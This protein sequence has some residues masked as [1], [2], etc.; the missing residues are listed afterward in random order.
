MRR[1]I[2][3]SAL[4]L[5]MLLPQEARPQTAQSILAT[6]RTRQIERWNGVK[7]YTLIQTIQG[8]ETPSYYERMEVNGQPGFRLV[9]ITE[10]RKRAPGTPQDPDAMAGGMADALD[11]LDQGFAQEIGPVHNLFMHS[12]LN[13]MSTVLRMSQEYHE[14][15]GRADVATADSGMA[16]FMSRARLAGRETM[17]GRDAFRLIADNVSDIVLTD[18]GSAG[19]MIL[20]EL[21]LWI[22]A[23]EY[24]PLVLRMD[25]EMQMNGKTTP[26]ELELQQKDYHHV[27]TMFQPRHLVM[28]MSGMLEAMATDPKRRQEMAKARQEMVKARAHWDAMQPQ[29]A[30]L[31]ASQKQMVEGQMQ[32]A[33]AQM[34]QFID[35]GTFES[36]IDVSLIGINEGP[37]FTWKPSNIPRH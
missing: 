14:N 5:V 15:D 18:P 37:P 22:D 16:A 27:G 28:R 30:K 9:P 12:M 13:D 26:V 34:Q 6:A 24:V 21:D 32:K 19:K 17:D 11:M 36:V 33:M 10:W 1:H 23:E 20:R 4:G 35:A 31:N 25:G 8:M 3:V 7:N 29:L 2:A